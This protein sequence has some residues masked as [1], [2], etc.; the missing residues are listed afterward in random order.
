MYKHF[1][2][3]KTKHY[4]TAAALCL[5]CC[6][7][8]T[9]AADVVDAEA[10][11]TAEAIRFTAVRPAPVATRAV[12]GNDEWKG[13]GTERIGVELNKTGLP[14][15]QG[16]YTITATDGTV[17]ALA[18]DVPVFW[19][20]K[21]SGY[22]IRAC[23]PLPDIYD[24]SDQSTPE[25]LR[26]ADFLKAFQ[27]NMSY[28]GSSPVSLQFRHAMAKVRV[29]LTDVN[30]DSKE[31]KV[32]IRGRKSG[33]L[34]YEGVSPDS[35]TGYLTACRDAGSSGIAFE[36][37]MA[38]GNVEKQNFLRITIAGKEYYFTPDA[39]SPGY[40]EEGHIYTYQVSI[41]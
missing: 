13:D 9:D 29:E 2:D 35:D 11:T 31:I 15:L 21:G 4:F 34:S 20:D 12:S 37:M 39:A 36:A 24:I 22:Q 8:C 6:A 25:K 38:P 14:I 30:A 33:V 32:E 7:A 27:D 41:P 28:A 40:L 18:G 3:M 16:T 5:M 1:N 17:T 10:G 19:P 26:Q 23:Y